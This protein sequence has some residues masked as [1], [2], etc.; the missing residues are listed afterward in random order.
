ME[1]L[2]TRIAELDYSLSAKDILE[3][4][5][6]LEDISVVLCFNKEMQVEQY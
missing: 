5:A 3:C 4:W 2:R 6:E 1:N